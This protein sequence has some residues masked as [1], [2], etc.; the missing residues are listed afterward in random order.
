MSLHLP[1]DDTQYAL[2]KE[3]FRHAKAYASEYEDNLPI[4]HFFKTRLQRVSEMLHEFHEGK[5]LDVGCG[6]GLI[7]NAFRGKP[8]EYYGIDI[9]KEMIRECIERFSSDPG[10]RFSLGRMESLSFHDSC[11]DAVLCLGAFEYVSEPLVAMGEIARVIRPGGILVISMLNGRCPY[12]IWESLFYSRMANGV[13]MLKRKVAGGT[14]PQGGKS[15]EVRLRS[16][17]ELRDLLVEGG[18]EIQDQVYYDFNLFFP[19][20]DALFPGASVFLSRKLEFLCRSK[21]RKLGT[22]F[23]LKCRKHG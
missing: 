3:R 5:V 9:S 1:V 14:N 12:R 6:P 13:N 8:I 2:A 18:F 23:L 21:L 17:A 11:F 15:P 16:E 10:F 7:G 19:P 4:S 22:G 20:L